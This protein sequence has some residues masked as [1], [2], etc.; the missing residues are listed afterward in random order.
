MRASR[1]LSIMI[2]LQ[3][4]GRATAQELASRFEV[5]LR[6]IYRDV[7]ELSAA[8]VPVQAE[9]GPGGGF[10]LMAGY[11]TQL[12]GLSA[13]E[14]EALWLLGLPATA[15]QLGLAEPAAGAQMKLLAA[16][17]ESTAA[18]ALRVAE[19]FHLDP[20]DWYRRAPPPEHL[21][22][23]AK[24]VWE[25][26]AIKVR[27]ES[28]TA[29]THRR[30]DPLGLVQKAGTWYLVARIGEAIRS[31]RVSGIGDVAL[32]E[33]QVDRP[34]GFDLA[35]HWRASVER[36]EASLRRETAS[37]RVQASA[38]SRLDRLGA[39]IAEAVLSAPPDARGR[40]CADVPIEGTAHAAALLLGFGSE[41]E[42][43]APQSLRAEIARRAAK[44]V[45]LYAGRR[46][47]GRTN[48][49]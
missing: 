15:A 19:R 30:L 48:P 16:M 41:I 5:S 36:F 22:T 33:M 46:R 27:Y 44:V 3:V 24:A 10:R 40:R 18:G 17:P 21:A 43:I 45:R 32:L 42:V 34:A 49:S 23:V 26:R 12:T 35:R 47:T 7:D 38:L 29:T 31:Y 9:R 28:W 2:T 4:R 8:G 39:D 11:R 13:A 20:L 37:L 14:G 25:G 1:L 6:T